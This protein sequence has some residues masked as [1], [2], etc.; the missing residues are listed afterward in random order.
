MSPCLWQTYLFL[1]PLN[2][3]SISPSETKDRWIEL[4]G[5]LSFIGSI[6]AILRWAETKNMHTVSHGQTLGIKILWCFI[7]FK[8]GISKLL[9]F[10]KRRNLD[11]L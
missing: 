10:P 5:V 7:K 11:C 6:S 4:I 3:N 8:Q 2:Q 9:Y 1:L